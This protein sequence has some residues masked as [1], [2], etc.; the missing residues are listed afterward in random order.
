MC[1]RWRKSTRSGVEGAEFERRGVDSARKRGRDSVRR[2]GAERE[3][4][5]GGTEHEKE[6][7]QNI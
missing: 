6:A 7:E 1:E 5:V 4:E 2:E 3:K